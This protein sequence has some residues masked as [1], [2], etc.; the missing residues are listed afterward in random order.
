GD[1]KSGRR[2]R[3]GALWIRRRKQYHAFDTF[4]H[5]QRL[6]HPVT[7]S[8]DSES[9]YASYRDWLFKLDPERAHQVA[10]LAGRAG[11]RFAAGYLR[12]TFGYEHVSLEQWLW[13]MRFVNPIGLAA[14]F[15]KNAR[16]LGFAEEIGF[17][18][19]E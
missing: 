8:N 16:L 15:D 7:E 4:F 13:R 5:H 9:R 14:G 10:A 18:F 1:A 12:R 3:A 17:G 2:L 6:L 11:H 19:S